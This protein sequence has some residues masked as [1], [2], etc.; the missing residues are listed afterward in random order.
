[1]E[2]GGGGRSTPLHVSEIAPP[3]YFPLKTVLND[4]KTIHLVEEASTTKTST[5][6]RINKRGE[7]SHFAYSTYGDHLWTRRI[8]MRYLMWEGEGGEAFASDISED[9]GK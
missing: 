6:A 7:I 1:M 8:D 2:E 5:V 3:L 9:K 4:G